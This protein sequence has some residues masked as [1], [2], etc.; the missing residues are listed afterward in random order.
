MKKIFISIGILLVIAGVIIVGVVGGRDGF[1]SLKN[2]FKQDISIAD[3]SATFAPNEIDLQEI[4]ITT[5]T[6]SVYLRKSETAD[7]VVRYVED[8]PKDVQFGIVAGEKKIVISETDHSDGW[9]IHNLFGRLDWNKRF[10]VVELPDSEKICN[11]KLSVR[12][13]AGS[14]SID[15]VRLGSVVGKVDAG[16]AR[17]NNFTADSFVLEG[18]TGS[19]TVADS[20]VA[21]VEID[22]N[23]GSITCD[24]VATKVRLETNA[25]SL[26]F[27]TNAAEISVKTNAGSLRGTIEGS[28]SDYDIQVEHDAGSSN[29]RTDRKPG[30]VKKLTVEVDA[31]SIDIKFVAEPTPLD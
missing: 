4:E 27:H 13:N 31:G 21:V 12:T 24:V 30:A 29:I 5:N 3:T 14:L 15:G 26:T 18:S 6:Y 8:C 19:V 7:V 23:A 1:A 10:V 2:S 16:S 22:V 25:G 28:K 11:V 17:I 9:K 20:A